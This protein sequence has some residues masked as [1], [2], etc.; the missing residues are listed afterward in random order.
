MARLDCFRSI[1]LFSAE[2]LSDKPGFLALKSFFLA[3]GGG[4]GWTSWLCATPFVFKV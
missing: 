1:E 3:G 4:A 2:F